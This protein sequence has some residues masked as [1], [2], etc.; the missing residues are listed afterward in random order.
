M[1]LKHRV[2]IVL[3]FRF[4]LTIIAWIYNLLIEAFDYFQVS[5]SNYCKACLKRN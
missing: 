1:N 3:L 2:T 4:Y 5:Y